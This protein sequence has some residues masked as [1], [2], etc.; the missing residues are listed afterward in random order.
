MNNYLKFVGAKTPLNS[1]TW[2]KLTVESASFTPTIDGDLVVYFGKLPPYKNNER[3]LVRINSLCVFSEVFDCDL[4]DCAD[5]LKIAMTELKKHGGILFYLRHEGRGAG[6]AAKVKATA[7]EIEGMDTWDSRV[8]IGVQ[9]ESRDFS[10]IGKF[11]IKNGIKKITLLTN[12]PNK[13]NDLVKEGVDVEIKPLVVKNQN[14]NVKKLY[15]TKRERFGHLID[16]K[17]TDEQ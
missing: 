16:K 6:L 17:L 8:Q 3:V 14:A 2:G 13:K 7:L 11:L 12:N 15:E 1:K 9:P 4:C 10:K 5:Q